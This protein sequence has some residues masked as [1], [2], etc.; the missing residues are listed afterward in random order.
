MYLKHLSIAGF[1][2]I[3]PRLDLPLTQRTIFYGSNGSGKT[4]ILQSIAWALYGKLPTFSGGV[5]SREDAL[6]NDFFDEEKADV[7]LTLSD[8]KT[9]TR[10]RIKQDSTSKGTKPALL[11]FQTQDPEDAIEKLLGLSPEEFF[12]A[13]FLHQETIRDFLTTTPEKRSTTIDRMIGTSLLRA[14]I[15]QVDPKVPDKSIIACREKIDLISKT[16]SQASVLNREIIEKKKMQYGDP[17]TL[18]QVLAATLQMLSPILAEL[19]VSVPTATLEQIKACLSAARQAQLERVSALTKQSGELTN[20]QERLLNAAE[21]N[22]QNLRQQQAEFGNPSELPEISQVI[23]ERLTW[24]NH[25]INLPESGRTLIELERSLD[26]ARKTQPVIVGQLGQE[27]TAIETL[28]ARYHQ[29]AVTDWQSLNRRKSTFGDP[30]ALPDLLREI[31]QSLAPSLQMLAL[32]TPPVDLLSLEASLAKARQVLPTTTSKLERRAGEIAA[33]KESYLQ[34]SREIVD[35][36]TVPEE[37]TVRQGELNKHFSATTKQIQLLTR[38]RDDL[39]GKREKIEQ[40][41][42]NTEVLPVLQA[43]IEKLR[44]E[45]AHLEATSKQGKLYNQVL[46]VSR[47]YLEQTQPDH[48]PVCQQGIKDIEN[49]LGRLRSETPADLEQLRRECDTINKQLTREQAKAQEIE[50]QQGQL[51]ALNLEIASFPPDLETQITSQQSESDQVAEEIAAVK[52]EISQFEN[53]IRQTAEN[54]KRMQEVVEEIEEVLGKAAGPD[55]PAEMDQATALARQ[56]A[57]AMNTFEF[58][59]IADQLERARKLSEIV[60]EET[61]LSRNLKSVLVD[62][63]DILGPISDD[64]IPESFEEAITTLQHQIAEI[65][66]LDFQLVSDDLA[67]AK[68]LQ[69]IQDEE[70]RLRQQLEVVQTEIYQTLKLS[71][72]EGD[73]K[74]ALD[75]AINEIKLRAA[76]VNN[77]DLQP[78]EVEIQRAERL[79]EILEDETKLGDLEHNYHAANRE[80]AR[81]TYQIRRLTELRD[82]LQ[83][84]AET[85]KRHQSEIIT[86]VLNNLDIHHYYQQLDPHPAYTALQIEPELTDKGTYNYWIKALTEDYSHGTYVQTRFSTAQANCAAIAIFLAVN[87]HLSKNLET[88]LLDDPSQSMDTEHKQRLAQTLASNPRQVIVATEDPQMYAFLKQ[89]FKSPTVY[90]LLPWTSEGSKL[91]LTP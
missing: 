5:Y 27:V 29:T 87:Q 53:R 50:G 45:L 68:Q 20:L 48:C 59:P 64:D 56:Q 73:L 77:I 71:I 31:Q 79:E 75:S 82:A 63:K 16:L 34:A 46:D 89:F 3:G 58:E 91:S 39:S 70:D 33:L 30:V 36:V 88:I 10:R 1:R 67:H 11:S 21:T 4:S 7:I 12:T 38:Q 54:R 26:T 6:V 65:Q 86:D 23:Q 25:K 18:P 43:E 44:K 2:G 35:V 14:L 76:Y 55:L 78:I 51:S 52:L 22:W 90:E 60:D 80:K 83:D 15:K 8:N 84:I 40:L 74:S 28:K 61:H 17:E 41:Q 24:L 69:Q 13:V 81:L 85:T 19:K 47:E 62:V 37:L 57:T 32:P 42:K 72:D 49:L 66:S 9:I